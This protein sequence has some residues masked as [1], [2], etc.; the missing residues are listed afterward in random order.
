MIGTNVGFLSGEHVFVTQFET[1]DEQE[2]KNLWWDFC[3]DEGIIAY[4]EEAEVLDD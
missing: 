1:T 4:V 3:K 2:L